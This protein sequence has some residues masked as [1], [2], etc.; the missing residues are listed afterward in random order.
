MTTSD[1]LWDQLG[2]SLLIESCGPEIAEV[3]HQ[4]DRMVEAKRS[5]WEAQYAKALQ[6]V[7]VLFQTSLGNLSTKNRLR[8]RS[9][10]SNLD[11][12]LLVTY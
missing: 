5:E 4:V 12:L 1:G 11:R 7:G 9:S 3:L 2:A 8:D 10:G 6:N